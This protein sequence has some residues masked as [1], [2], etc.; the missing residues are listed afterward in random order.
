MN[1]KNVLMIFTGAE[2]TTYIN[3]MLSNAPNIYIPGYEILD[4]VHKKPE[5][6]EEFKENL[7]ELAKSIF[8]PEE[9]SISDEKINTLLPK[10]KPKTKQSI[11]EI[12]KSNITFL[13]WRVPNE[14]YQYLNNDLAIN[15]ILLPIRYSF[16]RIYSSYF[17]KSGIT[18]FSKF[19][20]DR[21]IA[22]EE[23]IGKIVID[24]DLL[25]KDIEKQKQYLDDFKIKYNE[26]KKTN[27]P[28]IIL[29]YYYI[30]DNEYLNKKIGKL[31]DIDF[32]SKVLRR[33]EDMNQVRK[34][35]NWLEL[36]DENS[37]EIILKEKEKYE[38]NAKKEIITFLEKECGN[39][40]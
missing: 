35:T 27:I 39:D 32:N 3:D 38:N 29:D 11:I 9:A 20:H 5:E 21:N 40:Y 30:N 16:S 10:L 24:K 19:K 6:K 28:I 4:L 17:K 18:I 34:T 36:F 15:T 14:M 12:K 25:D 37:K 1:Q 26:L 31:F 7:L 23:N 13:K 2:G 8:N 22:M 33:D